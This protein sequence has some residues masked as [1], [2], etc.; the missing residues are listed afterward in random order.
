[1][2]NMV[3]RDASASKKKGDCL[4]RTSRSQEGSG[5]QQSA[6]S[7]HRCVLLST[8]YG[9]GCCPAEWG[10]ML[11]KYILILKAFVSLYIF[12]N[13]RNWFPLSPYG[14]GGS[15]FY[16]RQ[17]TINWLKEKSLHTTKTRKGWGALSCLDDVIFILL[18]V[19]LFWKQLPL[20]GAA[21]LVLVTREGARIVEVGSVHP[22]HLLLP[23]LQPR[24][25]LDLIQPL[26]QLPRAQ[27]HLSERPQHWLQL[28]DFLSVLWTTVV[29]AAAQRCA[30]CPH[31]L[32][33]SAAVVF[34][35]ERQEKFPIQTCRI[36]LSTYKDG[37]STK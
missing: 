17:R 15:S 16:R 6:H 4:T 19:H 25:P 21:R 11:V 13:V 28:T 34:H 9:S 10:G 3:L 35:F 29:L 5:S 24:S 33:F 30:N 26:L 32:C 7:K 18:G 36:W 14:A 23:Q 8:W 12:F 2:S 37:R 22:S 20:R 1:M 27:S 31:K